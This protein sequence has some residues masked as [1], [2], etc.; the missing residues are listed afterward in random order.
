MGFWDNETIE[1]AANQG[2]FAKWTAAGDT[3]GGVIEALGERTFDEGTDKERI[4]VE[5]TFEDGSKATCG[6]VKLMQ[7]LLELRPEVGETIEIELV[8]TRKIGSKT[9]KFWRVNVKPVGR[10]KAREINQLEEDES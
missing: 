10:G 8:E 1:K 7:A 4:A 3:H 5:L 6:Q 2:S 9:L